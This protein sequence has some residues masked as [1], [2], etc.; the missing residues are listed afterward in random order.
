MSKLAGTWVRVLGISMLAAMLFPVAARAA[1]DTFL[2]IDGVKGGS[3]DDKH[4]DWIEIQ[5]FD[6]GTLQNRAMAERAG[7]PVTHEPL[8]ITRE[9]DAASPKLRAF[10][11]S[12]KHFPAMNLDVVSGG[13]TLHYRLTDVTVNS[14]AMRKAGGSQIEEISFTYQKITAS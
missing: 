6:T 13:R 10:C 11:A 4:K 3:T 8:V 2:W 12:G 1:V 5:S 14:Y 9:V 7:R